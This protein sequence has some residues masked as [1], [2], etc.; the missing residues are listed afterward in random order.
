MS[1]IRCQY[2]ISPEQGI[3]NLVDSLGL[4]LLSY[5]LSVYTLD[6]QLR[7]LNLR[8]LSMQSWSVIRD[9]KHDC[10]GLSS[11]ISCS[12]SLW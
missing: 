8:K 4:F 10:R 9:A 3:E 6:Q 7:C 2:L 12:R 11:K 5:Y 1:V